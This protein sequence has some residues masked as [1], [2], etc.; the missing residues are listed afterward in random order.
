MLFCKAWLL[1]YYLFRIEQVF[2]TE[3]SERKM[4]GGQKTSHEPI[5]SAAAFSASPKQQMK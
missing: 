2:Q 1:T 3:V 4:A 5:L